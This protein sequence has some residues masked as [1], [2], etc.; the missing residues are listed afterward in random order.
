MNK[1]LPIIAVLGASGLIGE[2]IVLLLSCEGF[3]V[4]PIARRFTPA[5]ETA[6]GTA[7][8]E[9]PIVS[10]DADGLAKIFAENKI[11]IVVN[12]VGVLQDSDRGTTD[13]VHRAFTARLVASL[14]SKAESILLVHLSIPGNSEDDS[15][16]FSRSKREAERAIMASSV[17]FLIL[18]P[19][20]VVAPSAYG[21]SALMRAIAALPFYFPAGV[22]ERPFAATDVADIARTIAHVARRWRNGERHWNA[23]WD[24]M[25]RRPTTVGCV[26]DAF[27]KRLGGPL[28]R[29]VLPIWLMQV[30]ARAGDLVAHLG[31]SPP[32][33]STSLLELRRG[34]M[35]DPEPWIVA[36]GIEPASLE[37][38]L[39]RLTVTV[40]EKWFARLYLAKALILISLVAFWIL[41]GL[42]ALMPAFNAATAI[43]TSHGFPL[44]LAKTV[45][46]VS[47]LADIAIG[48]AITFR[49]T[50][51]AG[52]LAGIALSLFY[53]IGAAIITPEMWIE[54]LGALVKT[55]PAIVLMLVALATLENR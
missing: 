47:S 16:P 26:I 44:M 15:T 27:R 55:V 1:P 31:W 4:V 23:S 11:D 10:M 53:M 8:V 5:Q 46:V 18:R 21:G 42:I 19:G 45:T 22:S 32:I 30:G 51:P 54:P 41:S 38:I 2:A 24:V 33:R 50:C 13:M 7:A 20:F 36:S 35:G 9:C 6:F 40:Q 17:P 12:C 48:L 25:E 43:L 28:R 29:V 14:G 37:S 34:V 3:S 39:Q 49:R 52:L